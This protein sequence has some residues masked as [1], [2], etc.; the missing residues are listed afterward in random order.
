[1]PSEENEMSAGLSK[2]A[3][4]KRITGGQKSICRGV[5]SGALP[6]A[7]CDSVK[8]VRGIVHRLNSSSS[9]RRLVAVEHVQV[10]RDAGAGAVADT[11]R[12]R[13]AGIEHLVHRLRLLVGR[14]SVALPVGELHRLRADDVERDKVHGRAR[15][16][17]ADAVQRE[18]PSK[19]HREDDRA[20]RV[21][22]R[23]DKRDV[24]LR[25]A[26]W[27]ARRL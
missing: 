27:L 14:Q 18:L 7:W 25:D 21:G 6:A 11:E 24:V 19:G 26:Q 9:L 15:L 3:P 12:Q 4:S 8:T 23:T 2:I 16:V 10:R 5:V 13:L 22:V 1:M 17:G 20:W